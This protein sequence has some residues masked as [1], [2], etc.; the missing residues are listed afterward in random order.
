MLLFV[1]ALAFLQPVIYSRD[2][3]PVLAFHCNRCHG[4][5]S[6]DAGVD[7]RSYS[8]LIRTANLPLL[9]ELLEGKRGESRR[10]PREAPPLKAETIERFRRWVASG[11]PEDVDD[12]PIQLIRRTEPRR[13]EFRLE[14][15]LTGEAYVEI[16]FLD[17]E[18]RV[19]HREAGV[20]RSREE[21]IVRSAP[22][23]PSQLTLTMRTRYG[24]A[25]ASSTLL[26]R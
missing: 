26:V 19:L 7:T 21:W 20:V 24:S 10:M 18:G 13:E 14:V 9:L 16:E 4:D 2:I 15:R 5:Q 8:R 22:H 6:T 11:A 12:I 3:A 17:P 1:A 25:A 23:W